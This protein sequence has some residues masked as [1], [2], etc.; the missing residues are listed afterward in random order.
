MLPTKPLCWF[1]NVAGHLG[2]E[3]GNKAG[4][5]AGASRYNLKAAYTSNL[6]PHILVA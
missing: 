1:V 4:A 6:R 3:V 5:D 2:H